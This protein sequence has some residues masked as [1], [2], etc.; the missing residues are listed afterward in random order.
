LIEKIYQKASHLR[1][2]FREIDKDHNNIIDYDELRDAVVSLLPEVRSDLCIGSRVF[3]NSIFW[4]NNRSRSAGLC[5]TCSVPPWTV[6]QTLWVIWLTA[7]SRQT[8][9]MVALRSA[10]LLVCSRTTM[11]CTATR[12]S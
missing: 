1:K 2:M 3:L 12:S 4:G 8:P 7:N 10:A 6:F 11:P 9:V 5:W